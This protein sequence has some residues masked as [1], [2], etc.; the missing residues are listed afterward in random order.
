MGDPRVI[1]WMRRI[2][3]PFPVSRPSLAL[4]AEMLRD[5]EEPPRVREAAAWALLQIGTPSARAA[6]DAAYQA[7]WVTLE[8][9]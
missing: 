7:G 8:T 4:A 5:P 1:E 9:E 2:G 3:L 6:V